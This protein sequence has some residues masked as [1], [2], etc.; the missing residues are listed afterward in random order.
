MGSE[1]VILKP[2]P[3][4]IILSPTGRDGVYC[5]TNAEST[6]VDCPA[7]TVAGCC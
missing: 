1:K 6:V 7:I 3:T 4:P 2:T 5:G